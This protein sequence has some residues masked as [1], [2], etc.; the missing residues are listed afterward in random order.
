[1]EGYDEILWL[2]TAAYVVPPFMALNNLD[3]D[4]LTL[5][6]TENE[7]TDPW[8]YTATSQPFTLSRHV[9]DM[10][11]LFVH[12]NWFESECKMQLVPQTLAPLIEYEIGYNAVAGTT[13][14]RQISFAAAMPVNSAQC[15]DRIKDVEMVIGD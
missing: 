5:I 14:A 8:F 4:L 1:M 9:M 3:T 13:T 6:L 11:N 10:D 15:P 12:E 7:S 2:V